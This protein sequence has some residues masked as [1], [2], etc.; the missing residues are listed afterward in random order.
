MPDAGPAGEHSRDHRFRTLAAGEELQPLAGL[1]QQPVG[2]RVE[3]GPVDLGQPH[4][5]QP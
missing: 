2:G 1:E 5:L 3:G 4:P